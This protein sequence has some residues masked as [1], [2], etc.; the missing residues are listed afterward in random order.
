MATTQNAATAA[1][2][3]NVTLDRDF[4]SRQSNPA[5]PESG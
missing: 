2:R 5:N 1:P 4:I 3:R